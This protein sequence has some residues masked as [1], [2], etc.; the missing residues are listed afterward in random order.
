VICSEEAAVSFDKLMTTCPDFE[1]R[2]DGFLDGELDPQS[3]RAMALHA[4]QCPNCGRDL[5]RAERL[6]SLLASAVEERVESRDV[7]GLWPA[8]AAELER[9]PSGAWG[10]MCSSAVDAFAA[11]AW[12]R[13]LP[14]LALSG[15]VAAALAFWMWPG[16]SEPV[17]VEIANNHAQIER[18]ASSAPHVAVWS[19]PENHTTA[20]WVASYEPEGS[21]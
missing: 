19:E 5:E 1:R 10:R 11:R 9:A 18:I 21:P 2:F 16:A 15:A 8:I 20:I 12:L 17:A 6:Q 4:G 14:A 7:S 13:P 3:L